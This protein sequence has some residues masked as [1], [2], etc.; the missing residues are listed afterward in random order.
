[1]VSDIT[2]GRPFGFLATSSDVN[3]IINCADSNELFQNAVNM[4]PSLLWLLKN[5]WLGHFLLPKRYE[6]SGFGFL[7]A[8][9]IFS[10]PLLLCVTPNEG[11]SAGGKKACGVR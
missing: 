3:G 6:D 10:T 1:M 9:S 5:T 4:I 7:M 2:Y 8:A 11:S